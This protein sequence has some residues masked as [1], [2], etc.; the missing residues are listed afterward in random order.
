MK[1]EHEI[2]PFA[3]R[4]NDRGEMERSRSGRLPFFGF[5]RFKKRTGDGCERLWESGKPAFGFP[6]SH[7]REAGL[8]ECGNLAP[9]ARFPRDGGRRGKAAFAFPRLPRARHFHSLRLGYRN[10]GGAED[11]SL[12]CCSNRDLAAFTRRAHAVSLITIASRSSCGKLMP[13]LRY[14]STRSSDF[15]FSNG[16]R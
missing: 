4:E 1:D 3:R 16:V 12:H 14:C 10:R 15:S 9:S 5:W 8:W 13:G 2:R 6:L 11:G 7:D